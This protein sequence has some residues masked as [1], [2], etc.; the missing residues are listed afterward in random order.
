LYS[1][2]LKNSTVRSSGATRKLII[3]ATSLQW[4]EEDGAHVYIRRQDGFVRIEG[5]KHGYF[6]GECYD[7][8]VLQLFNL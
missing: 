4:N 6:E 7:L 1:V 2:N 5:G 3:D 8:G